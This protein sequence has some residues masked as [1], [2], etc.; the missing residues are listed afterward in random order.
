MSSP[1]AT[2]PGPGPYLQRLMVRRDACPPVP[3]EQPAPEEGSWL[4]RLLRGRPAP[5]EPRPNPE[6]VFEIVDVLNK[7]DPVGL[8]GMG[9]PEDEYAREARQI[10]SWMPW[11]Q[12]EEEMHG[13][14]FETFYMAFHVDIPAEER[15]EEKYPPSHD[16]DPATY[17][18]IAHDL[19]AVRQRY[20]VAPGAARGP[21]PS[22]E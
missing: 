22:Q 10:A 17:V 13:M 18:P 15:D 7:H 9:A 21:S 16:E 6:L 8:I 19:M 14:V 1:D 5:E 3:S 12:D 20:F 11:V 4:S 2:V